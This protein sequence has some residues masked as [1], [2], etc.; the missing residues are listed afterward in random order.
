M[1]ITACQGIDTASS[2][3]ITDSGPGI[4]DFAVN[5]D[6]AVATAIP[7]FS[8]N[9]LSDTVST[10]NGTANFCGDFEFAF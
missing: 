10:V 4:Q 1:T 5:L 8:L 3:T 6:D 7:G 2:T 9:N